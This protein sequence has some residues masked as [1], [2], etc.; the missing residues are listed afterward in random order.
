MAEES[1]KTVS[2]KVNF[3]TSKKLFVLHKLLTHSLVY[4][5][6]VKT[7]LQIS[8]SMCQMISISES[9]ALKHSLNSSFLTLSLET[10]LPPF[11]QP[12]MVLLWLPAPLVSLL[13]QLTLSLSLSR[14]VV[15]DAFHVLPNMEWSSIPP[16]MAVSVAKDSLLKMVCAMTHWQ[17]HSIQPKVCQKE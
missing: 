15:E 14:T 10:L 16:K 8:M 9:T 13:A 1:L 17:V 4:Q 12:A 2:R 6:F 11:V 3:I 5:T 7:L